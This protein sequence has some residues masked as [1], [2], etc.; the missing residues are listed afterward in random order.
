MERAAPPSG[1]GKAGGIAPRQH[2]YFKLRS[3]TWWASAAP[4][5]FGMVIATEPLHGLAAL[6]E[7]ARSITG[8]VPPAMLINA[9][10]AGIGLRGALQ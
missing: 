4:L 8:N 1:S 3:L 9:G 2:R 6:A 7:T 5:V 10:L